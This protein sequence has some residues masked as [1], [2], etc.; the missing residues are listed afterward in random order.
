VDIAITR[1]R[2]TADGPVEDDDN[3]SSSNGTHMAA[4]ISSVVP[5]TVPASSTRPGACMRQ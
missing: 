2:E 5:R 1:K 4:F 3:S